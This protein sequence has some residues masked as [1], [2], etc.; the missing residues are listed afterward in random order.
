M[1]EFLRVQAADGGTAII[2]G[3]KTAAQIEGLERVMSSFRTQQRSAAASTSA[4]A[5]SQP[6][7]R[8]TEPPEPGASMKRPSPR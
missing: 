1:E 8:P 7:S 3:L 2:E 6:K 4:T 5:S